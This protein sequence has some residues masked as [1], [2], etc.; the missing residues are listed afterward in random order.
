MAKVSRGLW[1]LVL[2]VALSGI[3]LA[4]APVSD[5]AYVSSATPTTLNGANPSLVVQAP[6][7]SSL[8]RFDLSRLP[9]G[10][11]SSQV[12]RATVRAYVTAVAGQGSFDL[13]RVDTAWSEK[14]ITYNNSLALG[15]FSTALLNAGTACPSTNQ[16]VTTTSKYF[17]VDVT[18]VVRDWLDYQNGVIGAHAN[19]GILL[20]PSSG[21][22]ISVTFDS[23][24]STTSSHDPEL[25]IVLLSSTITGTINGSQVIGNISGNAA[26]ATF[27]TSAGSA[28]TA[29]SAGVAGALALTPN[30]CNT[31]LFA[32]GIQANGNANCSAIGTAQLPSTVVYNNQA[33][34]F[35]AGLKQ[36]FQS[37]GT[38]GLNIAAAL[39]NT[40]PTSPAAGDVWFR[41]DLHHLHF[42]D[43]SATHRLMFTDDTIPGSQVTGNI[44]GN[45]AS[46]TGSIPESQVTNLPF[47][48]GTLTT[49][50][51]NETSARQTADTAE[52]TARAAADTTL[53]SNINAEAETRAAADTTLQ[54]NINTE[55]AARALADATEAAARMAADTTLQNNIDAETAQQHVHRE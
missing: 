31:N 39:A 53:Q 9:A 37:N 20:K 52:A 47:D 6:G 54:N 42:Y 13:Y 1:F 34:T 15:T 3:A 16:C 43:G 14:T 36:I 49:N 44:A 23:K 4:Q 48:L 18:T 17:I 41:L 10:T 2:L 7:G 40:N 29:S 11:T 12:T 19:N 27:A 33:N 50:L 24:E 55:A 25:N 30:Q 22:S 51:S 28:T 8:I 46:I 38:A 45:A 26:T 35:G 21:S 5:D 32:T